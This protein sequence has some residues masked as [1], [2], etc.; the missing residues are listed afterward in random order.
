MG[1]VMHSRR[2]PKVAPEYACLSPSLGM[3]CGTAGESGAIR[4]GI[5][6][7][8]ALKTYHFRPDLA[9][10]F[11]LCPGTPHA[12]R[13][14]SNDK[15]RPHYGATLSARRDQEPTMPASFKS[16]SILCKS[17]LQLLRWIAIAPLL[18]VAGTSV[19]QQ[20]EPVQVVLET[21]LGD[22]VLAINTEHAPLAAG[23]FLKFI[24]SGKYDSAT[25]YRSGSIDAD[26]T[27][28]LIQGGVLG[29]ALNSS[30][31]VNPADFGVDELLPMWETTIESGMSHRRGAISLARDLLD[32]GY[33]IPEIVF[34]LRD[35]TSMDGGENARPDARGF[36]VIGEVLSGME[37]LDSL[38]QADLSGPTTI[39][40]LEGQILAEQPR[41]LRAARR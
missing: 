29:A 10:E 34:C 38:T 8:T 36:P 1:M 15:R 4:R 41:I 31:P 35:A 33:V 3:D 37:I 20:S 11:I 2:I 19:A 16:Y 22:I 24:D 32:T 9:H 39:L 18:L 25:L 40:F 13:P 12:A 7:E 14:S 28:Q 17:T 30:T 26:K 23:Y 6:R 27:P 5:Y 21:E